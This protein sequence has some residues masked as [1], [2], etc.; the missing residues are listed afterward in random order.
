MLH[1]IKS[2]NADT[3]TFILKDI[4]SKFKGYETVTVSDTS[5]ETLQVLVGH[6][7]NKTLLP[8]SKI[9][10]LQ[11]LEMD[12]NIKAIL[13]EYAE[14]DQFILLDVRKFLKSEFNPKVVKEYTGDISAKEVKRRISEKLKNLGVSVNLNTID[15]LTESCHIFLGNRMLYSPFKLAQ[16]LK[17]LELITEISAKNKE[18]IESSIEN[19]L[20]GKDN[21]VLNTWHVTDMYMAENSPIK[22]SYFERFLKEYD[23]YELINLLRSNLFLL[24]I[25]AK[26]LLEH[27][28]EFAIAKELQKNPYFIKNLVAITNKFKFTP[29]RLLTM[30]E[31]LFNLEKESKNGNIEDPELA[32]QILLITE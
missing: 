15:K 16:L 31:R 21:E 25:I 32:F 1:I 30:I 9:Y 28:N 23:F 6:L 7:T 14:Q 12:E 29:D 20:L 17:K 11:N 26:M 8:V 2:G 10:I 18:N 27:K 3:D 4:L 19:T 5:L 13:R 22:V 24:F